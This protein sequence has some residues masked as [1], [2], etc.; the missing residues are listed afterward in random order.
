MVMLTIKSENENMS[1][2]IRKN[3]NS[4]SPLYASSIVS[5]KAYGFYAKEDNV[6]NPQEYRM[7]ATPESRRID[8]DNFIYVRED[9]ANHHWLYSQAI[10]R[11]FSS[12]INDDNALDVACKQ[13]IHIHSVNPFADADPLCWSSLVTDFDIQVLP[14]GNLDIKFE[15]M[16]TIKD[17]LKIT[18]LTLKLLGGKSAMT[19]EEIDRIVYLMR[20]LGLLSHVEAF[21]SL[22]L[23]HPHEREHVKQLAESLRVE[24][25]EHVKPAT[26]NVKGTI[27]QPLLDKFKASALDFV[28]QGKVDEMM[29]ELIAA[30]NTKQV[31][32]ATK[33][34]CQGL[35][36]KPR[37]FH[38]AFVVLP[39]Y[40][41][42]LVSGLMQCSDEVADSF[43]TLSPNDRP[44]V[45]IHHK[46][47]RSVTGDMKQYRV[48]TFSLTPLAAKRN[49]SLVPLS[50]DVLK[51]N[52][53]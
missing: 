47:A 45:E 31:P 37:R 1:H 5:G 28:E 34:C 30:I 20:D 26:K 50:I 2:V 25:T 12:A 10:G 11:T 14:C 32:Y 6:V 15:T 22:C 43:E 16:S 35:H 52:L 18:I 13:T 27:T 39:E 21:G 3:P 29:A 19:Y 49:P 23:C 8:I 9:H 46:Y 48:V 36:D 4:K 33:Y 24:T 51:K 40:L 42:L 44:S 17:A 41:N 7:V 53:G 38:V